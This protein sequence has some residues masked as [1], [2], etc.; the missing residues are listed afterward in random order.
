LIDRI[1]E[2]VLDRHDPLVIQ[3]LAWIDDEL[4]VLATRREEIVRVVGSEL[5]ADAI[6]AIHYARLGYRPPADPATAPR[7]TPPPSRA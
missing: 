1:A 6:A 4:L 7:A 5:D 3:K 2:G